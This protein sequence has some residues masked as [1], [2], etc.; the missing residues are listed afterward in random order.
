MLQ[1]WRRVE[2]LSMNCVANRWREGNELVRALNA[3]EIWKA[4]RRHSLGGER[5]HRQAASE[6]VR[7]GSNRASH[8][9]NVAP[10]KCRGRIFWSP[11]RKGKAS[12]NQLFS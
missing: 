5:A 1:P 4:G 9:A 12:A 3:A 10:M 11:G 8:G 6:S 2:L 7:A